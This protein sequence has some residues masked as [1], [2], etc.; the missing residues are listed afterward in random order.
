MS[1]SQRPIPQPTSVPAIAPTEPVPP[2]APRSDEP[3]RAKR[4]A[5]TVPIVDHPAT[6][7]AGIGRRP[8]HRRE[9][10]LGALLVSLLIMATSIFL[11]SGIQR[12]ATYLGLAVGAVG[13]VLLILHKPDADEEAL[14]REYQRRSD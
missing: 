4:E 9:P 10:W 11:P 1:I 13:I 6:P 8:L 12:I 5:N 2:D 14:W 7:A 3:S